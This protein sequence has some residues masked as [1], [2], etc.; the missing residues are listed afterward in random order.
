MRNLRG[1]IIS[2]PVFIKDQA[3]NHKFVRIWD[4]IEYYENV[5]REKIRDTIRLQSVTIILRS[6]TDRES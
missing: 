4:N 5:T 3:S 2:S 6:R 1:I